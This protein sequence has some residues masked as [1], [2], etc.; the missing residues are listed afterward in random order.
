MPRALS[1]DIMAPA[2]RVVLWFIVLLAPGGLLLLPFLALHRFKDTQKAES[3]GAHRRHHFPIQSELLPP[4]V[5][6]H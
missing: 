3:V 1:E 6:M 4:V 2:L 5:T